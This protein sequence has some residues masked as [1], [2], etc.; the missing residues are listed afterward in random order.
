MVDYV[1]TTLPD[2]AEIDRRLAYVKFL[3]QVNSQPIGIEW[4]TGSN[5]PT[6]KLID[7]NSNEIIPSASFFDNHVILGHIRRC[8]VDRTTHEISYGSNARGDGLAL[9]GSMGDIFGEFP[10]S[11]VKYQVDGTKRRFWVAPFDSDY[12]GFSVHPC[13]PQRSATGTPRSKI[14]IAAYEMSLRDDNGTLKGAS[15]SGKQPW[16]GGELH[17]LAFTSGST[18]F[19][20]GEILTGATSGTTA[21]VID[22][23]LTGGSWVGGDAAGVVYLKQK[24]ATAF[25]AEDLNGATAG[26]NCASIGGASTAISLTLDQAEAYANANGEGFGI[27]NVWSYAYMQLLIYIETHTLDSQTAL[28]KGIVDLTLGTGYAGKITGADSIDSLL[29]TNGTGTGSGTNGQTPIAWRGIENIYGNVWEFIAGLNMFLSDGTYRVLKRDG[30]GTP[31]ATL[32]E[33]SYETGVGTVPV[34]EDGYISGIQSDELGA[35]A[36][37]PSADTGSSSYYLCD[38]FW[39]PRTNPSTVR[40]GG[41]WY[42]GLDAGVGGRFASDGLSTSGLN[43]GARLEFLP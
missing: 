33:G 16:T 43:I 6:L 17:S 9:D 36:F 18:A 39:Y 19:T 25:V 31:A 32:A 35:M 26:V 38:Y 22:F 37:I 23:H 15:V 10:T 20:I 34:A 3:E 28:G 42:G 24:S 8:A 30:T 13:A 29:G 21:T 7:I 1:S 12:P 27:C 14:Y 5:S 4:E 2:G 40:F 11:N 41:R